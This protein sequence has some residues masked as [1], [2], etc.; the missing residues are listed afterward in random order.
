LNYGS[1]ACLLQGNMVG[2]YGEWHSNNMTVDFAL[3]SQGAHI[4]HTL[5]MYSSS[6][7][8]S[9]VELGVTRGFLGEHAYR[10]YY[11]VE[12]NRYGII[13]MY[14]SDYTSP[15]GINHT[16]W[17]RYDGSQQFS[18][19]RDGLVIAVFGAGSG[20]G[21]G[22]CLAEAGLEVSAVTAPPDSRFHSDTFDLTNLKYGNASGW[23]V[24]PSSDSWIDWPCGHAQNP[25]NCL[26]GIYATQGYWQDN[27]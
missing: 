1:V 16:Y 13:N 22:G 26:N 10:F 3:E 2:A 14:G 5:W 25:P 19:L 27:K 15:D 9:F 17:V 24:W 7:C 8:T 6:P 12:D 18:L 11:A 4:N 20:Q 23:W 21:F